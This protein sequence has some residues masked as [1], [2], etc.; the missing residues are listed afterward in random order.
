MW[1]TKKF[2]TLVY[3]KPLSKHS[4]FTQMTSERRD[5]I[6]H[7]E[8]WTAIYRGCRQ[9]IHKRV[10]ERFGTIPRIMELNYLKLFFRQNQYEL[11]IRRPFSHYSV[12]KF[13]VFKCFR[14]F[15]RL[16]SWN[17]AFARYSIM[18]FR[19]CEDIT[20]V[21]F[22]DH[23]TCSTFYRKFYGEFKEFWKARLSETVF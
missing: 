7:Q 20:I 11:Q 23:K 9:K 10:F 18:K 16:F 15:L 1:Y 2:K 5:T 13:Q 21:I 22:E 12:Q 8:E 6:L 19:I 3:L 4:R 17:L 14:Y